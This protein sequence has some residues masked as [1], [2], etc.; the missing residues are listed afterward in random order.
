V[1]VMLRVGNRQTDFMQN[2]G[3]LEIFAFGVAEAVEP[4]CFVEDP[5]GKVR[6]VVRVLPLIAEIFCEVKDAPVADI[7][8]RVT[9]R[10]S[11]LLFDRVE[12]D[13]FAQG[14]LRVSHF[15]DLQLF[16]RLLENERSRND[17][18]DAFRVDAGDLQAIF[19]VF[20]L[21]D[22]VD[23]VE[24]FVAGKSEIVQPRERFFFPCARNH[25]RDVENRPGRPDRN[26]VFRLLD[27]A[28]DRIHHAENEFLAFL[29]RRGIRF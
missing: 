22:A 20:P 25:V 8:E 18:V 21:H 12:D 19:C 16:E 23:D 3:G 6:D 29:Y 24:E 5:E 14:K 2:R 7:V 27:R 9:V 15:P 28:K 13:P 26:F 1:E 10:F 4:L 11:V 17:D